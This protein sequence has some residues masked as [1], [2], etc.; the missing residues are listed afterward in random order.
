VGTYTPEFKW[1]RPAPDVEDSTAFLPG[2]EV[3]GTPQPIGNVQESSEAASTLL[4]Q[5]KPSTSKHKPLFWVL[6]AVGLIVLTGFALIGST[7]YRA[8]MHQSALQKFWAPALSTPEP[9][10]IC[11]A[12]PSV[13]LPSVKLY[14]RHSKTPDKFLDQFQRLSEKPDLQPDDKLVWSDMV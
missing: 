2:S 5:A 11:L 3:Q 10:L 14:Q 8:R 6:S 7:I 12:K 4:L 13:Y 1:A 9:I